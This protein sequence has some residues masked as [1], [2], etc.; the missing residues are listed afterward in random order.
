MAETKFN[1]DRS[2]AGRVAEVMTNPL[3]N[4]D[5]DGVPL[6]DEESDGISKLQLPTL[7]GSNTA[8]SAKNRAI[9]QL[10][11]SSDQIRRSILSRWL[12]HHA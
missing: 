8:E 3:V 12:F 9:Q 11:T 2:E 4:H 6:E 1:T 7:A 10:P 5:M